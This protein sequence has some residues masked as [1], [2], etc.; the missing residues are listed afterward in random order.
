MTAKAGDTADSLA[1]QMAGLNRGSELFY[2]IND[3]YPGDPVVP[4]R[5]TRSWRCSRP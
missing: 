5:S 1:R 3:L 2:I 4:G